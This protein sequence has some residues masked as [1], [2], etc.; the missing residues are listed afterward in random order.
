VVLLVRHGQTPTT[1]TTR[2]GRAPGL[3][4]ADKG[5]EQAE[6]DAARIAELTQVTAVYASPLERTPVILSPLKVTCWTLPSLTCS[7]NAE[8]GIS[9]TAADRPL[10]LLTTVAST[11]AITI[12]NLGEVAGGIAPAVEVVLRGQ[13][14]AMRVDHGSF[15]QHVRR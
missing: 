9:W 14:D 5:R 13:G 7:R 3:H 2:P 11:T 8:Y 12:Q 15:L 10:K 6:A 1:G 4:L